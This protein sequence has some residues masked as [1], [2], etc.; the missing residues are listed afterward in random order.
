MTTP[1]QPSGYNA[2]AILPGFAE[3]RQTR[4]IDDAACGPYL[5]TTLRWRIS[6]RDK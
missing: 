6:A 1:T 3:N 5:T 4:A 2:S